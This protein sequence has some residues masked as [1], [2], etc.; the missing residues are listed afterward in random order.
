MKVNLLIKMKI[1][2][3]GTMLFFG[4]LVLSSCLKA[5]EDYIKPVSA[6]AVING[7][8]GNPSLDFYLDNQKVNT[9]PFL[10]QQSTEYIQIFSGIRKFTVTNSGTTKILIDGAIEVPDGRYYSI[11]LAKKNAASVD[12]IVA[13]VVEDDLSSPSNG[14][15]K[16]RFANLT[17]D[18]NSVDLYVRGAGATGA[19]VLFER[20]VFKSV[21]NFKEVGAGTKLFE[22]R[23]SGTPNSSLK[24]E[25]TLNL[26]AGKIYTLSTNGLWHSEDD[27]MNTYGTQ[28]TIHR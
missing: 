16:I 28:L 9:Q 8:S 22:I 17:P 20:Q 4:V 18:G 21:S 26:V 25:V 3:A 5:K 7:Y 11:F 23:E 15:A 10:Y 13:T 2:W 14:K 12:S 6:V 24:L 1:I 19:E 27:E